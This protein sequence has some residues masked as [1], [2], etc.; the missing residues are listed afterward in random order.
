MTRDIVTTTADEPLSSVEKIF[1]QSNFNGLPVLGQ[2]GELIGLVTKLDLLRAFRFNEDHMFPPYAELMKQS[3]D[4]V[5][6]RD[7]RTV[8]PLT[9]LTRVLEI[10]VSAGIKSLPVVDGEELVGIVSRED[11]VAALRRASAGERPAKLA[12]NHA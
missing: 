8:T 1:E 5:M 9:R 11:V 12:E 4:S 2:A 10:L 3:V 6:S 7:L